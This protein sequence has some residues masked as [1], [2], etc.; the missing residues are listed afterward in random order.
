MSTLKEWIK[1]IKR[2]GAEAKPITRTSEWN[3]RKEG[4]IV[5]YSTKLHSEPIPY[6]LTIKR[7]RLARD[8][9]QDKFTVCAEPKVESFTNTGT[10]I[11][12]S[13]TATRD[14]K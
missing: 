5:D 4:V 13:L 14:K 7:D 3:K 6:N 10:R 8:M 12:Y 1:K 9:R 11:I 2:D